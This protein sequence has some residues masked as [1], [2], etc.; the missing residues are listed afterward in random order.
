[1]YARHDRK[2]NA[3]LFDGH[4]GVIGSE[5][6]LNWRSWAPFTT[7]YLIDTAWSEK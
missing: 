5:Q 3:L 2:A 4:V 7:S 1:P 6:I